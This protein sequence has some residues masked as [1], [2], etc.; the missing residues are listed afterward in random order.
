MI[1]K[2]KYVYLMFKDF[3]YLNIRNLIFLIL[4]PFIFL[5]Q[6]H[7]NS[8][9]P[10]IITKT[11]HQVSKRV[12]SQDSI[13]MILT[14]F[15]RIDKRNSGLRGEHIST[16]VTNKGKFMGFV[17]ISLDLTNK[18][19]PSKENTEKITRDYLAKVA[20]DLLANMQITSINAYSKTLITSKGTV[21]KLTGMRVKARNKSDGSWF[22]VV[23]AGNN[24][25]IAF[26]RDVGW[27]YL[28]F[29][30]SSEYWLDDTWL[31]KNI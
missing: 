23:V 21:V 27:S 30:R 9:A 2:N 15:E 10:I 31:T 3:F 6:A 25:P 5:K 28:Q 13:P 24:K 16:L 12:V 11:Y 29:K 26:E 4:L 17:E 22:W 18:T 19:L 7:S 20:P 14:R 8:T 1:C